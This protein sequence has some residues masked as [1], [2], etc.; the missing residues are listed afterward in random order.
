MTHPHLRIC[1]FRSEHY[2]RM[3]RA[4]LRALL[5]DGGDVPEKDNLPE[6]VLV[7]T[8]DGGKNQGPL[9]SIDAARVYWCPR[10][11]PLPL[12]CRLP[13]WWQCPVGL[14]NVYREAKR[15]AK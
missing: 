5:P 3:G 4:F 8:L 1:G 13:G 2:L 10:A 11:P 6:S 12:T 9:P 15:V 7:V 14:F